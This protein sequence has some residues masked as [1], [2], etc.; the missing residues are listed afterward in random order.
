M[1]RKHNSSL[2]FTAVV[3]DSYAL[4]L[5]ALTSRARLEAWLEQVPPPA[6]VWAIQLARLPRALV[7]IYTRKQPSNRLI[8]KGAWCR[9]GSVV[10]SSTDDTTGLLV[11]W[12]EW[13]RAAQSELMKIAYAPARAFTTVAVLIRLSAMSV[14][15]THRVMRSVPW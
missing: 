7:H 6:D 10:M 14:R 8:A 1:I 12:G 13:N 3:S 15:S 2:Q 9:R 5:V 4:P 11:A